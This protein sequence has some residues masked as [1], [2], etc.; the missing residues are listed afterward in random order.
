MMTNK[1]LARIAGLLYLIVIGT[2]LFAE[3]FVRQAL[4]VSGDAIAT[5]HNIQT[6][7]MLY[8]LGFV[9]DL[10]NFIIGLP[11]ILIFYILFKQVNKHLA[12]LAIFFVIIQTAIIA[13]NL[14]NQASPLLF[15]GGGQYLKS[16]Q[17]DQLAMLS[18]HALDLQAEG[19]AIGLVFFG[20]YCL[21][22]GYLIIESTFLPRILGVL[23][24]LAGLCYIIN[25]YAM[26]LS[27]NFASALFPYIMIPSF[28]GEFSVSLW[29]LIMGVKE[30][31]S[32]EKDIQ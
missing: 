22:I 8:R 26:F 1:K 10:T 2:G 11:C 29:L 24:G 30:N 16:F 13:V 28:V 25:S 27:P 15:L 31:K 12:T 18:N 19:Y 32:S 4:R 6:S 9:A 23:Y 7:E 3:V 20:F 14:L 17:P 5:A 21:I